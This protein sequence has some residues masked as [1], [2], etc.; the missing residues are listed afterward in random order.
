MSSLVC[1]P[2][3]RGHL[4]LQFYFTL[5]LFDTH[6]I[7][8]VDWFPFHFYNFRFFSF[9]RSA[10]QWLGFSF[11]LSLKLTRYV[12]EELKPRMLFQDLVSNLHFCIISIVCLRS[13]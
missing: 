5:L 9:L 7:Y 10:W 13:L 4:G 3:A 2:F 12:K 1:L 6:V 8:L 11:S